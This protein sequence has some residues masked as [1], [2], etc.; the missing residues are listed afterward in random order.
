MGAARRADRLADLVSE[1][2]ADCPARSCGAILAEILFD[3]TE[4]IRRRMGAC[5]AECLVEQ[6][7]L[8]DGCAGC[9]GF[10]GACAAGYCIGD[11]ATDSASEAC[12]ACVDDNCTDTFVTCTGSP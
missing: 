8:S 1:I 10:I 11:C 6:T 4:D 7:G 5:I 3:N 2:A 12:R 9:Y